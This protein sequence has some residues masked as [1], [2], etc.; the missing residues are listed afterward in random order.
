MKYKVTFFVYNIFFHKKIHF[1]R[2][3]LCISSMIFGCIN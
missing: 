2:I 3:F 1:L